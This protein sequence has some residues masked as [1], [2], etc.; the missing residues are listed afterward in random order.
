L[1]GCFE[2]GQFPGSATPQLDHDA[3][4]DSQTGAEERF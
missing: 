3:R 4:L 1:Y 2:L